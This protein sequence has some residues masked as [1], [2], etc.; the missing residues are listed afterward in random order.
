M[1][2]LLR[3]RFCATQIFFTE[4]Y[5]GLVYNLNSMIKFNFDQQKLG[6]VCRKYGVIAVYVHG[7]RVKG[8]AAPD[9][10][11]DVA[12][13]VED[14]EKQKRGGFLSYDVAN[15]IESV[16]KV[17]NPDIRVVDPNSSPIF[18]FEIIKGQLVFERNCDDRIDFESSVMQKYYDTQA[19]DDIY[20][21]YL[22]ADIKER[23]YAN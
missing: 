22:F 21:Q 14:K 13:V 20:R 3:E 8:Y 11:T 16:L 19:M 10:D 17:L 1:S 9:S 5:C 4:K 2:I 15:E 23:A 18:L 7:S 12:V 6:E